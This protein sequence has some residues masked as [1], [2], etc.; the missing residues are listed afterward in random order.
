MDNARVHT[1]RRTTEFLE[2]HG[3]WTI[4]F[5]PYS[6]DLNPIEHL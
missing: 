1:A 3:I 5:P 2:S 6:P 4:D